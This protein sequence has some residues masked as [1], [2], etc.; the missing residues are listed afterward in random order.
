MALPS[1]DFPAPDHDSLEVLSWNDHSIVRQIVDSR[2]DEVAKKNVETAVSREIKK[3]TKVV[4][5]TIEGIDFQ[6]RS[7]LSSKNTDLKTN[8][9]GYYSSI[10]LEEDLRQDIKE[11]Y[12]ATAFKEKI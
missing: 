7:K 5:D 4:S 8:G 12:S 10:N 6:I 9:S 1:D 2:I 11:R 3:F